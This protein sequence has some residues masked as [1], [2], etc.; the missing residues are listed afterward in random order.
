VKKLEFKPLEG[1]VLRARPN[2][3]LLGPKLGR[4]LPEVRQALSEGKFEVR[5]NG[6]I[7]VL[8]YELDP[9]EVFLER[10][11]PDGWAVVEANGKIVAL[12]TRQDP[13]LELEG[14]VLDLIHTIQRLRKD[15]GLEITDRIV[16][17][18]PEDGDLMRHEEWIKAETLAVRIERGPELA[19]AKA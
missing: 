7:S 6:R 5:A 3:P 11:A 15:S 2:L 9:E 19:I 14:R 10:S 4:A 18:L 16:V 17:T 1:T 13:E 12:V 8:D